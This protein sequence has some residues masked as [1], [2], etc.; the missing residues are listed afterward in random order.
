MIFWIAPWTWTKGSQNHFKIA[1]VSHISHFCFL[2]K[3]VSFLLF[4][5]RKGSCLVNLHIYLLNSKTDSSYAIERKE[6]KPPK[7]GAITHPLWQFN[8]CCFQ[9]CS[10]CGD[11]WI[12][13]AK[14]NVG[15]DQC[16]WASNTFS[17]CLVEQKFG[18][19]H[20]VQSQTTVW[21]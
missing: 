4:S 19:R 2:Q 20:F 8:T 18:T 15:P 14:Q 11:V 16:V 6:K 21:L 3:M 13:I 12:N 5:L 17:F 1:D 9:F 7:N 10:N